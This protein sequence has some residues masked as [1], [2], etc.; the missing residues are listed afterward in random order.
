[1]VRLTETRDPATINGF[2]NHPEIRPHLGGAGV[3]DL[4]AGLTD[5]NVFLFGEHG[6]FCF[7]WSAPETFEC[8]VMLTKAWRG[9]AGFEA[10]RQARTTMAQR[11]ASHLWARIHPERA[12]IGLYARM[13]GFRDTGTTHEL[14]AG[15][16]PVCWRIFNWRA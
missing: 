13:I 5:P 1:V 2:A 12:E 10:G 8:H 4:S 7:T 9:R 11:G 14:D 16:G 3:L 6:G 15:D